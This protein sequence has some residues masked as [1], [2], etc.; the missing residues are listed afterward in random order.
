MKMFLKIEQ[1]D[2][3]FCGSEE[4]LELLLLIINSE[5]YQFL[6]EEATN[7][8]ITYDH[9]VTKSKSVSKEVFCIFSWTF[10]RIKLYREMP[11][12]LLVNE[13]LIKVMESSGSEYLK[14][15]DK[16]YNRDVYLSYLLQVYSRNNNE[17]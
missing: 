13:V 10:N 1:K 2:L 14:I 16:K 7:L 11:C 6:L 3:V 15:L 5:E 8:D 17:F 9:Y 12:K 4:P